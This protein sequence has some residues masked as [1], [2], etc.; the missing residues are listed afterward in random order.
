M[1]RE[2]LVPLAADSVLMFDQEASW[3][4]KYLRK[5]VLST[6]GGTIPWAGGSWIYK[7]AN[8]AW[9]SQQA[10]LL[11]GGFYCTFMTVSELPAW[12]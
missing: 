11:R 6:V 9:A 7:E 10:V 3:G 4:G 2:W 5:S 12:M 8:W 1:V